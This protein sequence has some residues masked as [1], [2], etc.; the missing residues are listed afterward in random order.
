[1][2]TDIWIGKEIG[3]YR[4]DKLIGQGGMG[5]VYKAYQQ[6]LERTVAVKLLPTKIMMAPEAE[7]KAMIGR[8]QREAMLA[9]QLQHPNVVQI[10]DVG[11]E[12]DLYYIVMQYIDGEDL[13]RILK[14]EGPFS[15][16]D[17]VQVMIEVAKALI[18]A[19]GN[20][21]LHRD[22]KPAN[23]MK[24][25]SGGLIVTDF[26]LAKAVDV[27]SE[28]STPGKLIGTLGYMSPEQVQGAELDYRSDIYSLGATAFHLLTGR[29]PFDAKTPV[30]LIYKHVRE[31]VPKVELLRPEVPLA[32]SGIVHK[33]MHRDR[34]MRYENAQ[35]LLKAIEAID[36]P[37]FA[38][39][40]EQGR[41]VT[42]LLSVSFLSGE[43]QLGHRV[44]VALALAD[45][46]K[47]RNE[48]CGREWDIG[49]IIEGN[50]ILHNKEVWCP[51]C[52][53]QRFTRK[54]AGSRIGEIEPGSFGSYWLAL[55]AEDVFE[56]GKPPEIFYCFPLESKKKGWDKMLQRIE[57]GAMLVSKIRSN[58]IVGIGNY[59][60]S[61]Q[62]G[63]A[64]V[65]IEYSP[66]ATL[67]TIMESAAAATKRLTLKESVTVLRKLAQAMAVLHG[68]Y[69]V[70]RNISPKSIY[71]D[72]NGGVKLGNFTMAKSYAPELSSKEMQTGFP[73]AE[74][75]LEEGSPSSS[76]PGSITTNLKSVVGT[77]AYMAPE[78]TLGAHNVDQRGD[79]WSWGVIAFGLLEGKP[80][81]AEKNPFEMVREIRELPIPA[82]T[83][84]VP[85]PLQKIVQRALD[86]N[87][88][89][90]YQSAGE[91][92]HA[93]DMIK[94]PQSR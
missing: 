15:I 32:L 51:Q 37:P 80:L 49:Q 76:E 56:A 11:K 8:F 81:F 5:F 86:R 70:H 84:S 7:K 33:M 27:N 64:Y 47:C 59:T 21:V 52:L 22:I 20:Q 55:Q 74:Y 13:G 53:W 23:I 73:L 65:P 71:I 16:E 17:T 24:R 14:D 46:N 72:L 78:Q 68:R 36:R 83:A 44:R 10:Y 69:V 26:G 92:K 63:I 19:H 88:A 62:P 79:L 89:K 94:L 38:K 6:K 9:G 1:M 77:L 90:R 75:L 42:Q 91:I 40:W 25:H 82:F 50:A 4:I 41:Q 3:G 61:P 35:S 12:D 58:S 45:R 57:R 54:M 66:S 93:L 34:D 28:L 43:N 48:K 85:I 29:L 2:S 67:S 18:A 60:Q 30:Q 87:L 31:T 39:K